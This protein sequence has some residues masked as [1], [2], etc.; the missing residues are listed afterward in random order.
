MSCP[1]FIHPL[2][3]VESEAIGDNTKIWPFVH[4]LP[5]ARI[6]KDCNIC[7]HVFIEN[8]VVLGD[9]VTVKS[10]VY[11][12]DGLIVHDGVFIGPN[13]TFTNDRRPRSKKYIDQYAITRVLD[14]ASLGAGCILIAGVTIGRHAMVGAGAVVS[15]D[16][17]D[18]ELV[19]GNPAKCRGHICRCAQKLDFDSS[20]LSLCSCGLRYHLENGKVCPS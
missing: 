14:G 7:E 15:R 6:G 12:W 11:M 20:G 3:L 9:A 8:Q 16:V 4:V 19:Y 2:A 18:Y 5:G 10:G 1:P 13:A 17:L